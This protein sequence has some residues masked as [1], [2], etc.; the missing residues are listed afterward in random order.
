VSVTCLLVAMA[1]DLVLLVLGGALLLQWIAGRDTD[2]D[3]WQT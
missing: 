1:V 3:G 2:H